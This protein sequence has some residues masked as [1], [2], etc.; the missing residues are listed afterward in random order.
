MLESINQ[1]EQEK[2]TSNALESYKLLTGSI[3]LSLLISSLL[4]IIMVVVLFDHIDTTNL[5]IWL[6]LLVCVQ[7]LRLFIFY[8]FS[9]SSNLREQNIR[10]YL[11]VFRLGAL[12]SG[13]TWGWTGLFFAREVELIYQ[14][15]I[16]FTLGGLAVG[17][18]ASMA[19]DK[20]AVIAFISAT[21]LPNTLFYFL[22]DGE[23]PIAM[24][25]MLL[26]FV[27]FLFNTAKDQGKS[28]H[29]N[30]HLRLQAKR[31]ERQFREILNFSPIA[32]SISTVDTEK[33]LFFNNRYVEFFNSTSSPL[34]ES[35]ETAYTI[36]ETHIKSIEAR[37]K[38]GQNVTNELIKVTS[39]GQ[40]GEKWCIGS[41]LLLI[42]HSVP[43]VLGWFYDISDRIKMEHQ[44]KYLAYHDSLTG[45][46]NRYL[47]EDR[48]KLS[49][50]YAKRS[51]L[52]LGVMFI[53]LDGFKT[54]NDTH[55]HDVGDQ[56]LKA[57][58]ERLT[59]ILR[60]TDTLSRIGGD[61]FLVLLPEIK[62]VTDLTN[63]AEKLLKATATP[64]I[65]AKQNIEV[66]ASIGVAVYPHHGT[67]EEAL[68]KHA[69]DAMYKAKKDGK[70]KVEMY[71]KQ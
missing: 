16:S 2:L 8:R 60:A 54:V 4:A 50:S 32:A 57:V 52:A 37:L 19:T 10:H 30:I 27:G 14:L 43:A 39:H 55:G 38:Q 20:Y 46:P 44:I 34:S 5:F 51:K 33:T 23:L 47:F 56:L 18:S 64:F 53:D 70:N 13:L 49:L 42:Y 45:L 69:D 62:D 67:T 6:I 58:A 28:I 3:P 7:L 71:Q 41:F 25:I 11:I 22:S 48:L 9:Y 65:I 1:D 17:A 68:L 24:G 59:S 31:D 35:E 12:A 63:I 61:E 29:D 21:L 15:F 36:D 40:D 66:S 26:L